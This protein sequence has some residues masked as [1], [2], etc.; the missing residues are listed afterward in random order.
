MLVTKDNIDF[1]KVNRNL[2]KELLELGFEISNQSCMNL[3]S[4]SL[5]YRNYNTYLGLNPN[6]QEIKR[7]SIKDYLITETS[8]YLDFYNKESI[9]TY[10]EIERLVYLTEY[11]KYDIFIDKEVDSNRDKYYLQFRL[12]NNLTKRVLF[13][14]RFQTFSLF[15]FPTLGDPYQD[16]HFEIEYFENKEHIK[17]S[18]RDTIK[19]LGRKLFYNKDI[20]NDLVDLMDFIYNDRD[21]FTDILEQYPETILEEKYESSSASE[22]Y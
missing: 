6:I 18:F 11:N 5:G 3:L 14:P 22:F 10:D 9:L 4:R 7:I 12:K 2:K 17:Y 20:H 19:H 1:K 8:E 21:R 15:V 13:S 16:Y